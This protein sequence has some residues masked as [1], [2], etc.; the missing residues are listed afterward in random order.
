MKASRYKAWCCT[1]LTAAE[2]L[3]SKNK[4]ACTIFIY[5]VFIHQIF[6]VFMSFHATTRRRLHNK[7]ASMNALWECT[8]CP[9]LY[10]R[11]YR[12]TFHVINVGF[13][14]AEFLRS[15]FVAIGCFSFFCY[16]VKVSFKVILT[17]WMHV[18]V[19][20]VS[21]KLIWSFSDFVNCK[22][23]SNTNVQ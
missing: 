1:L 10:C 5:F 4:E 12:F 18:R 19:Y 15:F 8:L 23:C 6:Y 7:L 2:S 14:T 11:V 3:E 9:L 16:P 22:I 20:M 17:K 21:Q 13:S